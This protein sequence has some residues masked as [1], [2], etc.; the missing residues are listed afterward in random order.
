MNNEQ[1]EQYGATKYV[2]DTLKD[3]IVNL[4]NIG[5]SPE[6]VS[7]KGYEYALSSLVGLC[8]R[9]DDDL[10][11]ASLMAKAAEMVRDALPDARGADWNKLTDAQKHAVELFS[12]SVGEHLAAKRQ[13]FQQE[14]PELKLHWDVSLFPYLQREG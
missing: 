12:K 13:R 6:K 3:F 5:F 10:L 7:E 9:K 8:N 2:K 4:M 11:S 1:T 14:H